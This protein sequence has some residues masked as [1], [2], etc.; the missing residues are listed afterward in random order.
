M[1]K[2]LSR[3]IRKNNK[4]TREKVSKQKEIRKQLNKKNRQSINNFLLK[5]S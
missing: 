5:L 1:Y 3:K 4:K 2:R